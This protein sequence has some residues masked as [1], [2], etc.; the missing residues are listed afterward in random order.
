M[1][2]LTMEDVKRALGRKYNENST[3]TIQTQSG[4]FDK[5][6]G[7]KNLKRAGEIDDFTGG[8]MVILELPD[9]DKPKK[10]GIVSRLTG[11]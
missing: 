9:P 1:G 10:A 3:Y 4:A 8:R 11:A 5:L 7:D 6:Y 2:C